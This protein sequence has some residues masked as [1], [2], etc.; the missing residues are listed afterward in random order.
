MT[1]EQWVRRLR[2]LGDRMDEAAA[3]MHPS[4]WHEALAADRAEWER[5]AKMDTKSERDSPPL[6]APPVGEER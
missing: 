4:G 3:S 1:T 2:E 5:L 6:T